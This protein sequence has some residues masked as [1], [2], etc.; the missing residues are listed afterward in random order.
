MYLD[1][2]LTNLLPYWSLKTL[3]LG[4]REKRRNAGCREVV[5]ACHMLYFAVSQK[6]AHVNAKKLKTF[7]KENRGSSYLLLDVSKQNLKRAFEF[8]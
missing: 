4:F 3:A 5:K 7:L 8:T 2:A 6:A 1:W